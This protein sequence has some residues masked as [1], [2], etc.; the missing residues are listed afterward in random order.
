MSGHIRT[1]IIT[2]GNRGLGQTIVERFLANPAYNVVTCGREATPFIEQT[3]AAQ[4]NGRFHFEKLDI[5]K[6]TDVQAFVKET[7]KRL[8]TIDV[9]VN[10]AAVVSYSV[11]GLQDMDAV[12]TMLDVN[13]RGTIAMTKACAR[14]MI[15][16][17]WGRIITITSIV[18]HV[19]YRGLSAYSLTKAGLDGFTR[20]IARE[21][22]PKGITVN[23]VSPGFLHTRMTHGLTT[24]QQQQIVRRTP[25][26]RLGTTADVAPVIEFL[27]S[28]EASFITGQ[29][30]I[31]DGGLTT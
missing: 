30:I 23:S 9:L 2:G 10:N 16:K 12:G 7:R 4:K 8:G 15:T 11:L 13:I 22:G 6:A 31:V 28:D 5:S 19:G 25:M 3:A 26:G 29:T 20:S 18:G 1:A 27:C 24:D 17:K 14:E 21:F